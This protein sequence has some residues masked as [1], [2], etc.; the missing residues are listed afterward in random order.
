[1]SELLDT[2]LDFV[3][4]MLSKAQI[5]F[6]SRANLEILLQTLESTLVLIDGIYFIISFFSRIFSLK[7]NFQNNFKIPM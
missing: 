1:M 6:L 2:Y 3:S 4:N 5:E 7:D